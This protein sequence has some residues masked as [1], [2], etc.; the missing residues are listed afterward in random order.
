MVSFKKN[1]NRTYY[2]ISKKHIQKYVDEFTF[3]FITKGYADYQ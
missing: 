2:H 3:R 1:D